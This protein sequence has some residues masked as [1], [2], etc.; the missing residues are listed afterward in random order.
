MADAVAE[1]APAHALTAFASEAEL[2]RFLREQARAVRPRSYGFAQGFS[3]QPPGVV[4]GHTPTREGAASVTNVQHAGVDEGDIVK[5]HGQHLVVLR[6]GRLFTVRLGAARAVAVSTVDAFAPDIDPRD[7]WYDEILVAGDTVVVVGYS[8]ARGGTELALFDIDTRGVLTYRATYHLHTHDYYSSRNYASR[9]I[10]RRLILYAPLLLAG[11]E[12]NPLAALP[13]IRKWHPGAR[14]SEFI[15]IY[16]PQRLYRPPSPSPLLT[17]HT[18]ISCDLDGPELACTATGIMGSPG[19]VF[20]VSPAAVYVWMTDDWWSPA[21]TDPWLFRLPLDGAEPDA[22]RVSGRPVD[23]FSFLEHAGHL[24]VL[25]RSDGTGEG[26]WQ[27]ETARG[28][29]ALLRLPLAAF[30][31][32]SAAP[33][34]R[35]RPLPS[36]GDGA[37]QNRFVGAYLLYGAGDAWG[38]RAAT[39]ASPLLAYE[40]AAGTEPTVIRVGHGVERIEALGEDALVVGSAG[41]DLE[42]SSIRLGRA[43]AVAGRYV[44]HGT[45]QGEWRSHG[46]FYRAE[47]NGTGIVGLPVRAAVSAGPA[48]L[49]EGSAAVLFLRNDTLTLR[50]LGRLHAEPERARADGCRASC[51]DWYGNAR[52]LFVRDRIFALLGYEL[53][54]GALVASRLEPRHR[55]DFTPPARD[56]GR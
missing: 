12:A 35:Y 50:E 45:A 37:F 9:L 2:L 49:T 41:R 10:G 13:A 16:S 5:V 53:V 29:V 54:E 52:P 26:M 44:V 30:K 19:R 43:P 33:S 38:K 15:P 55:V 39:T 6:R 51:V 20:Y 42:L 31:A 3:A 4:F 47:G 28:S 48:Y 21:P 34:S 56:P 25:V 27:S 32:M 1:A 36:P 11:S 46:F 17:L 7:A 40:Y 14:A 18:L 24:N 22:L 8:Y 23:Q